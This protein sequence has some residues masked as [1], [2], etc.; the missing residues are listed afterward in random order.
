MRPLKLFIFQSATYKLKANFKFTYILRKFQK[1]KSFVKI[2]PLPPHPKSKF[3][4]NFGFFP[5]RPPQIGVNF[6]NFFEKTVPKQNI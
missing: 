4:K 5:I 6:Q 2:N 1:F 3:W